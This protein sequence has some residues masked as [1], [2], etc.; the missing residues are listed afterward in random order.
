MKKSA[1]ILSLVG[2]LIL[3]TITALAIIMPNRADNQDRFSVTGSGVVYAKADIANIT[4]GFKT[5]LKKDAA[6]AAQESSKKMNA[7]I[8]AL[9]DLGIEEK[10]IK[11]TDYSLRP[12]YTWLEKEG[13]VLQGYEVSQSVNVKVRELDKIG[14]VI[15][16]TTEKGANQVGS[17]NF[18][19]DDEYELKN[20]ARE[21]AI[22][23]AKEKAGLIASQA[24]M[25]LGKV[26]SVYE[27]ADMNY[28]VPMYANAKMEMAD[29]LGSQLAVDVANIQVGQNEIR[30]EVTL[31]YEV[32]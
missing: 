26:K 4:V 16:K 10:D 20:Q 23:K 3:A 25:R 15:S 32:K 7:I 9:A 29:G 22:E 6:L 27:N 14:E 18:S 1:F 13:Q 28:P 21:L 8:E 24:N 30:V 19:I 12:V 17:V 11:T 5:E 2:L 31:V